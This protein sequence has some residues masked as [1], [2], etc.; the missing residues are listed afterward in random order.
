MTEIV[1]MV[2]MKRCVWRYDDMAGIGE[3]EVLLI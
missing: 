2:H 1:K 3:I